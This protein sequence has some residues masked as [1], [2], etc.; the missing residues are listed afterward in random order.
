MWV[1]MT[2]RQSQLLWEPP[3]TPF[4]VPYLSF[5]GSPAHQLEPNLQVLSTK[6]AG[7]VL[8]RRHVHTPHANGDAA[9]TRPDPG[10]VT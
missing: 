6:K 1:D 8:E 3:A 5:D 2:A 10:A 9:S 4:P 7:S